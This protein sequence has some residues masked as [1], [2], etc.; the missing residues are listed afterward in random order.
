MKRY[1]YIDIYF[2]LLVMALYY[3]NNKITR[4]RGHVCMAN[5]TELPFS[6][7]HRDHFVVSFPTF[8][9]RL[10]IFGPKVGQ[11]GIE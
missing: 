10:T 9:T 3:I 4:L 5:D 2:H 11:I 8:L 1:A 7:H 6:L